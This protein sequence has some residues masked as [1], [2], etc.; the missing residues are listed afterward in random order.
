M[1]IE[2]ITGVSTFEATKNAFSS[3]DK[4]DINT[5][6]FVVV[7]DRFTLQAEKLLFSTLDIES[8]FNINIISLTGLA[9]K[10][11][12]DQKIKLNN[13]NT[14]DAVL[15][16]KKIIESKREE[17]LFYK[18]S[19][20]E[21]CFEILKSI[22]QIKSSGLKSRDLNIETKNKSLYGK[23]HDLKIIFEDYEMMFKEKVDSSDI[24]ERVNENANKSNLLKDSIVIF[25]G[26]DSFT[27]ENFN[28]LKH[29]LPVVKKVQISL[30]VPASLKNAYIYDDDI[31]EKLK[32]I[33]KETE[34]EIEVLSKS[35]QLNSNQRQ[36]ANNL[37]ARDKDV[38]K[39]N[40]FHI[41]SSS[42]LKEEVEYA[43]DL[44]KYKVFKGERFK[45]F[46]IALGNLQNYESLVEE[47]FTTREIP[48][49]IDSSQS[50]VN[51]VLVNFILKIFYLKKKNYLNEDILYVFSSPLFA[52]EDKQRVITFIN[53]K[54]IFGKHGV[55]KY[56]KDDFKNILN[57]SA[58]FENLKTTKDYAILTRSIISYTMP[59]FERYL[60]KLEEKNLLKE[61]SIEEQCPGIIDKI[62][63]IF[64]ERDDLISF[65][66][67]LSLLKLSF[68]MTEVSSLPSFADAVF[69][70]DM[71]SSYFSETKNMIVLGANRGELPQVMNDNGLILDKDI[72]K[73]NLKNKIEPT[74]KMINRRNR[75]KLFNNLLLAKDNL[76][77][78]YLTMDK[79]GKQTDMAMF[80]K[81]LMTIF[82]KDESL[83]TKDIA[84]FGNDKNFE[85]FLFTLG[86]TKQSAKQKYIEYQKDNEIPKDY[87]MSLDSVLK[88]DLKELKLNREKLFDENCFEVFFPRKSFSVSQMERFYDCPFKH[89]VDYGLRL[90]EK[91]STKIERNE[92]GSFYHEILERFVKKYQANL[93]NVDDKE[94]KSFLNENFDKILDIEKIEF[95]DDREII[96]K[97]LYKEATKICKRAV[98]ENLYSCFNPQSEEF[99]IT[100][101]IQVLGKDMN[102]KGKVD[103]IDKFGEKFRV[104]DYKTGTISKSIFKD[105][106]YGKKIQLFVYS[107]ILG[108]KL[109]LNLSGVYYFNARPDYEQNIEFI[110]D[111]VTLDNDISFVDNRFEDEN[112]KKSD[113]ISA[114]RTKEKIVY[115]KAKK[116]ELSVF[117]DYA[118]DLSVK[119]IEKIDKG[120]IRPVPEQSSC[121]YCKYRGICLFN[122]KNGTRKLD[123]IKPEDFLKGGGENE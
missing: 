53:E 35:E 50:I 95:A 93:K 74:V 38:L 97:A 111:G 69:V 32:I 23:I 76:F 113:I 79:E 36:I 77:V 92:L 99:S 37:F 42:N 57:F 65:D 16:I 3:I 73:L 39:S 85:R 68:E 30:P 114:H 110:L 56:L 48:Y 119:A 86:G 43:A 117:E 47:V 28:L 1:K 67:F 81:E 70:G 11:L 84:Y 33:A 72:E 107:K 19:T 27:A 82:G 10:V 12:S 106:Y 98:K 13:L 120:E 123:Q 15:G 64:E 18:K 90:K 24:L 104:I 102:I 105:L 5:N 2:V 4:D 118:L 96:L 94:I 88:Y 49:Y 78:S 83:E 89:F 55:N 103:R 40:F 46:S 26:F 6:Y 71:T 109:G 115:N 122:K 9:E 101:D 45:D 62:L 87:L 51:S 41:S 100:K 20:P 121:K 17:L 60:Q 91:D 7:P 29:L 52:F 44:I 21:F 25:A 108:E 58:L 8:T 112:F 61:K 54:G 66:D 14:L 63:K 75:F 34:T 31:L 22:M 59:S 116:N 80:A